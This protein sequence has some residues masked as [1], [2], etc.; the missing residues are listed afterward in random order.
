MPFVNLKTV[1]GLLNDEQKMYLMEKF[2]ELL[3]ETEGGGN[4][5]FR[6]TVWINIEEEEP[7]H[8]QLGDLRPTENSIA[9]FVK[10]R[11]VMQ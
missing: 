7:K 3:I 10:Q 6:K 11:E 5:N 1:K 2:T 9:S 4:P 8:W